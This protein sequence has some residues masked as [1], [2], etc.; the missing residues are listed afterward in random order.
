MCDK[1]N[2]ITDTAAISVQ[3]LR[4]HLPVLLVSVTCVWFN[5]QMST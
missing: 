5:I 3:W 1:L 4:E 2:C